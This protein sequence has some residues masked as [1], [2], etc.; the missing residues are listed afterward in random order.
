MKSLWNLPNVTKHSSNKHYQNNCSHPYSSNLEDRHVWKFNPIG[1]SSIRL[2]VLANNNNNSTTSKAKF[3]KSI[4]KL[5]LLPRM[6]LSPKNS[7]DQICGPGINL[8]TF[9]GEMSFL[10]I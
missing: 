6:K 2:A 9:N 1:E 4:W 7:L 8:E 3:L 10:Q 5:N